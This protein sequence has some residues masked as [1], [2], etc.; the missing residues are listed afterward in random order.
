[1][2]Q[3]LKTK[4][5]FPFLHKLYT[6][7]IIFLT[8]V[9]LL[10]SYV[11]F[12]AI[13]YYWE[14]FLENFITKN[15]LVIMIVVFLV[16]ALKNWQHKLLRYLFWGNLLFLIFSLLSLVSILGGNKLHLPGI[17]KSSLILY[18]IGL[19]IELIFFLMGLT[20]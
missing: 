17:L 8:V 13:D 9:I 6:G 2:I 11:H 16:Y 12:S 5:D 4:K 15:V 14:N 10:Y 18:E 1:M 20:Y 7:G 19:L 3:F